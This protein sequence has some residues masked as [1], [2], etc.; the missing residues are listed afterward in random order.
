MNTWHHCLSLLTPAVFQ[1][2]AN[3]LVPHIWSG[4]YVFFCLL[5]CLVAAV[6]ITVPTI[7]SSLNTREEVC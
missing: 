5:Y 6:S 7:I 3:G 2:G 4:T 1:I